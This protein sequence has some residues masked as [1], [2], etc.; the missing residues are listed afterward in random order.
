V[1]CLEIEV[2]L[3]FFYAKHIR[4][5]GDMDLRKTRLPPERRQWYS[6]TEH[7]NALHLA[8]NVCRSLFEDVKR[9]YRGFSARM[10]CNRKSLLVRLG[11]R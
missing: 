8:Q 1:D 11:I 3:A 4:P 5:D 6:K 2:R 9:V 10:G 7:W